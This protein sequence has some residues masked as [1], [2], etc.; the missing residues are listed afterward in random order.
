MSKSIVSIGMPVFNGGLHLS[1]AIE[2]ILLQSYDNIEIIIADNG[3]NDDTAEVVRSYAEKDS[4]I[5]FVK[6]YKNIGMLD[7]FLY[8]LNQA[9]GKYFMW[10]AHDDLWDKCWVERLVSMHKT[11]N[12]ITYGKVVNIDSYGKYLRELPGVRDYKGCRIVRLAKFFLSE[13]CHGKANIIYGLYDTEYI[14]KLITRDYLRFT[15]GG[16]MLFLFD[17]LQNG[18]IR[19]DKNAIMY[20]RVGGEGGVLA[21]RR[22]LRIYFDRVQY[23][24]KYMDVAS[25]S[26]GKFTI[27]LLIPIKIIKT[28]I[29]SLYSKS[30]SSIN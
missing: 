20:K 12:I 3:S 5:T 19:I 13:E 23:I 22:G 6:H 15:F 25:G 16:D 11:S 29:F 7:N 30:R 26:R 18:N 9:S 10:A 14:R 28:V 4:R 8:V 24:F 21:D 17:S 2:S 1:E 27:G